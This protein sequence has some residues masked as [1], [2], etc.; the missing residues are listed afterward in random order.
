[1]KMFLNDENFLI[2][3]LEF[4]H[5]SMA[6]IPCSLSQI[7][8]NVLHCNVQLQVS[9]MNGSVNGREASSNYIML[10]RPANRHLLS[11]ITAKHWRYPSLQWYILYVIYW[12]NSNLFRNI[13]R[14]ESSRE[15]HTVCLAP[16]S[17]S[18]RWNTMTPTSISITFW[19]QRALRHSIKMTKYQHS[20]PSSIFIWYSTRTWPIDRKLTFLQL[21]NYTMNSI[22]YSIMWFA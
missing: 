10:H 4:S 22:G 6:H 16:F 18:R 14:R 19:V 13:N 1:M 21:T 9:I 11:F 5:H 12:Q 8:S 2:R 20:I 7:R 17:L 3:K 15:R